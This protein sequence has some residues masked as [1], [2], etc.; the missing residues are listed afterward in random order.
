MLAQQKTITSENANGV[1][2]DFRRLWKLLANDI[3]H[4]DFEKI[5]GI[6][7][8]WLMHDMMVDGISLLLS[9]A[10]SLALSLS[11]PSYQ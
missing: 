1:H 4:V 10:I 6:V 8:V 7:N 9:V 5:V 11:L 3:R 2:Q